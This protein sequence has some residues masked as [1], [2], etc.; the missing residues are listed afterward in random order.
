MTFDLIRGLELHPI[1]LRCLR[2]RRVHRELPE[3]EHNRLHGHERSLRRHPDLLIHNVLNVALE[4]FP[5]RVLDWEL[6]FE[7]SGQSVLPD[8]RPWSVRVVWPSW[9]V[10]DVWS[11]HDVLNDSLIVE[12][13]RPTAEWPIEA[14]SS[15][16]P[17]RESR[18]WVWRKSRSPRPKGSLRSSLS[19]L[20]IP[21]LQPVEVIRRT[22]ELRPRTENRRLVILE[23]I[24]WVHDA[25]AELVLCVRALA[26]PP[27]LLRDR[28]VVIAF[29]TPRAG[30]LCSV[31]LPVK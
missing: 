9:N 6:S 24:V 26:H 14:Q 27:H 18:R 4:P 21:Q 5:R 3:R 13:N 15:N 8:D 23:P 22:V 2:I 7:A 10:V 16:T 12:A 11:G 28:Q 17:R 29:H 19:A 31:L 25:D 30:L 20:L 1:W